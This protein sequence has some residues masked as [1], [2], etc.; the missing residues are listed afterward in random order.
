MN[1]RA[2][3]Y[4]K[5]VNWPPHHWRNSS[6]LQHTSRIVA[7][8]IAC[9][10]GP[11]SVFIRQAKT[12]TIHTSKTES[13]PQSFA[14]CEQKIL[15]LFSRGILVS[16]ILVVLDEPDFHEIEFCIKVIKLHC[17][18][19]TWFSELIATNLCSKIM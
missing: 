9:L 10:P 14:F 6:N 17:G 12:K 3:H 15:D 16:D 18:Q 19:K 5:L 13:P 4:W 1:H 8:L 11:L 2:V 7:I